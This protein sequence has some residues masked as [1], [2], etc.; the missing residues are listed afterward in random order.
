MEVS[1]LNR[2]G[3]TAKQLTG[4]LILLGATAVVVVVAIVSNSK[5]AAG[6]SKTPNVSNSATSGSKSVTQNPASMSV[7][8]GPLPGDLLIADEGNKRL[9][10]VTPQKK[11]VWSMSLAALDSKA[12][13]GADDSFLTPDKKHIIINEENNQLIAII[14]IATKKIVWTYGH[15]GQAGSK[16]GYLNTPDDA[17]MLPNGLVTVADIKNRRILEINPKT[18]KIVKQ[19]GNGIWTH[20]PPTSFAAPNGDTPLPDGGMLVTE[21]DGSYADRLTQSGKL[22]YTV[23]FPNVAYP[24]DTQLLP[25][26]NLLTV[27]YSLPGRIEE[28]TPKGAVVWDYFKTSGTGELNHPSLAIRLPNGYLALNDDYND[29]VI[30]INPAT[31]KIVWQYG[32]TGKESSAVGFLSEPDGIDFVPPSVLMK[33]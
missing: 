16:P 3:L 18:N 10:I 14:S 12:N 24:S 27:D 21:I 28:V 29:R 26:G 8:K 22:V 13:T 5:S 1:S 23:H 20:H 25:D 33:H 6:V 17:Y 30:I 9:L 4:R 32:K 15:A 19:I 7:S 31:K 11:I 2:K